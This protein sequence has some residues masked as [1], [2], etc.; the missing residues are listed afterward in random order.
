[1]PRPDR[2]PLACVN[3]AC[4]LLQRAGAGH[5]VIR[6]G[7]GHARMRL[8][9]GRT[10]GEACS[11]RRGP[12]LGNTTLPE[13]TAEAVIRHRGAGGSVRAPARLVPVAKETVARLVRVAGRQAE[14]GPDQ[15]VPSR[16][17]QAL[18]LEEPWSVGQKSQSGARPT[19]PTGLGLGG[20]TPRG[21]RTVT[22]EEGSW[23]ANAP[24]PPPCP[25]PR[26]HARSAS[27][28]SASHVHGC[29]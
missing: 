17:P 10:G 14:R 20:I 9:R 25:R 2:A 22:W 11:E 12:A 21:P 24:K 5:L 29:R 6:Q 3:P 16:T 7:Y 19:R 18:A 27:R 8:L 13:A 4:P 23:W 15:P 28:A 1:M 26:R